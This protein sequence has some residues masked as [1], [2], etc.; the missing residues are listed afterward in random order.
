MISAS[1]WLLP[2][3]VVAAVA[4]GVALTS[5]ATD[6]TPELPD[7]SAE[8]L[9]EQVLT[10]EVEAFSGT[11]RGNAELGLP[12]L[13]TELLQQFG[14]QLSEEAAA[15]EGTPEAEPPLIGSGS[16]PVSVFGRLLAGESTIGV[17]RDGDERQ[18]LTVI[19][20]QAGLDLVRNGDTGWA[21]S[22]ADDTAVRFTIDDE[23]GGWDGDAHGAPDELADLTPGEVAEQL[24]AEADSTTEIS[25][26][27][28]QV[29][30]GRDA[31]TL[32]AT[33]RTDRTLV[34]RVSIAVDAETGFVLS[35]TVAAVEQAEPAFEFGFVDLELATP[36]PATFEFVPEESTTVVEGDDEGGWP[37]A[38]VDESVDGTKPDRP[39][40]GDPTLD[41]LSAFGLP[42]DGDVTVVGEGWETVLVVEP[43]EGAG[44]LPDLDELPEGDPTED[45]GEATGEADPAAF[46]DSLITEV[47]GGQAVTTALLT[48]L[49]TDDG[50][51][52][53]GAVPVEV[54]VEI[55]G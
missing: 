1:R 10:A 7:V 38:G 50:R 17:A 34:E 52:L 11:I 14:D 43:P 9:V 40:H 31:Y 47:E 2:A 20:E 23:H 39:E 45:T 48:V 27:T 8:E 54:L 32:E 15:A 18:R 26:G 36:D 49:A 12:E 16:D 25:V 22:A 4:G 13:P 28:P 41:G 6:R 35:V 29:V 5:A 19:D 53:V 51:V 24:I 42:A 3:G 44:P 55:A 37:W 30:A 33:P 21:Y 46:V